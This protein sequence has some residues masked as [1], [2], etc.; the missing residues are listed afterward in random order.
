LITALWAVRAVDVSSGTDRSGGV[1]GRG[2][3]DDPRGWLLTVAGRNSGP[4][5]STAVKDT[6]AVLGHRP[7]WV[8]ADLPTVSIGVA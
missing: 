8:V 4:T 6:E 5:G 3:P 1:L 7:T 2:P